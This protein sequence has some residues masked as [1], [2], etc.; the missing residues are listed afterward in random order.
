MKIDRLPAPPHSVRVPWLCR[1]LA[2]PLVVWVLAGSAGL[3]AQETIV[4]YQVPAETAQ[5]QTGLE[6]V[7]VGEDFDVANDIIVT[8][9]GIFDS[10]SDGISEGAILTARLWDRAQSPP[11]QLA[12]I[13][14]D[15][16]SPGELV[17]GFRLKPLPEPIRL[18]AGFQGTIAGDGWTSTDS[19]NNSHGNTANVLWT[20]HDGG[21]SILFVGT[22]RYGVGVGEYPG[23]ADGGPAARFAAATFEFQT[24]PSIV[25]G[26]PIVSIRGGDQ[27]IVLTWAAVTQPAAAAKYVVKRADTAAGPFVQ[28][29]EITETTYTDSGLANGAARS[30]IVE[31][32]SAGGKAGPASD[33]KTAAAYLLATDRRIAYFTPASTPGNQSLLN[34]LGM[35]FDVQ[36]PI[37]VTR[38]GVFDANSDGFSNPIDARIFDR[39]SQAVIA[40]VSFSPEDPGVL[41]EGMRFKPLDPPLR[42]E[43]GFKGLIEA[44]GFLAPDPILNSNGNAANA[45]WTLHD[46]NASLVFVQMNLVG[47]I[48][49]E[50]PLTVD[51]GPVARY[52]A[53]TFEYQ[54]LP[55]TVVGTPQASVLRPFED[56]VATLYWPAVTAPL[57][58]AKYVIRR[59]ASES[60]PFTDLG[61]TTDTI[62]R[63]TT[64]QNGSTYYYIVRAV[65]T[66]GEFAESPV[67]TASPN[68]RRAGIAYLVP[69]G[70]AGNQPLGGS[71][72][73]MDFDVAKPIKVTKLGL[74]DDGGDGITMVLT[75]VL[76]DRAT[77]KII[78]QREFSPESQG[79]LVDGSRFLPLDPPIVLDT[80]FQGSIVM[81]FSTGDSERLYNTFGTPN[82]DVA[83]LRTFDGGSISFVGRS[84]YGSSGAFPA[85]TDGGPV[86]RY[87]GATFEF[88]PTAIDRPTFI[89]YAVPA[90]EAGNQN[91]TGAALGM[92]FDVKNEIILTRLGAFDDSSDGIKQTITVKIWNRSVPEAPAV[93]TSLLFTPDS[94]GTLI[95]GSRFKTLLQPVRL[96]T[97]FKG[98]ITTDGYGDTERVKNSH[99]NVANVT[100]TLNDGSGSLV[101][102]GT[103]RYGGA[104]G[105]PATPDGGLAAR[106]AAGTFEFQTTPPSLPGDP[107]VTVQLPSEENAVTLN[108]AAVTAPL[109]AAK[110]EIHRGAAVD[111]PFTALGETTALT[112][113]D[114]TA[115]NGQRYYYVV[116]AVGA[117]GET[118]DYSAPVL[119]TPTAKLPGI[120]YQVPAGLAGN[121]ALGGAAVG[122]DFDVVTPIRVT[123]LGLFD[124]GSDGITMALTAV[125]Y[126]RAGPIVMA[127]REFT[128]ENQGTLVG[129]SRFL[130]LDSPVVLEAGFQ[131]SIVMSFSDG[132]SERLFN[133][134]GNPNPATADLRLYDGG[135]ILFV[136]SSRYGGAGA[137][138]AT[139]DGG[140]VNRYAAATFEFEPSTSEPPISI[141]YAVAAN[142]LKLNWNGGGALQ[143]TDRI[144][145]T[146][147]PVN[148]AA[149]GVEIPLDGGAAAFFRVA[150]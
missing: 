91:V 22:S 97:G 54:V 55:P 49:G 13:D 21:G 3:S 81:W 104:G 68:P 121:Q 133:T 115:Q 65:A 20:L 30:Y 131:G 10:N 101:F 34:P 145:G 149:S 137:Y 76:Y 23:T 139:A 37:V 106:Y 44:D 112:Y 135:S 1:L 39:D 105:Y 33:I 16:S 11:V 72:V 63:D 77:R 86:N 122:M 29:A 111:G 25:P 102:V 70:L 126:D 150:K 40:G 129:G 12:S 59:G 88:E 7:A 148:G 31:A 14:F 134:F 125:L 140:P 94:P 79:E 85:T 19:I 36:N 118:G 45:I 107:I 47:S 38:L 50:Y 46:G 17:G 113:R 124:D 93:V 61:E 144:G 92:D 84:R 66:G 132:A 56:G 108:W 73:G 83:D 96:P 42:L 28:V 109:P 60:G 100:W 26:K 130:A 87:A 9:L 52:A 15:A 114:A 110:Y 146:W 62:Y 99:G 64:V 57:P 53:G 8:K 143:T 43:A 119:G 117:G 67:L 120:A 35:G 127:S 80:G 95:G 116:R 18:V 90:G 32:V 27:Q 98:T 138:P 5:N 141:T 4:A 89:A 2:V 75:A 103:S 142:K 147:T 41:I 6:T 48:P 69:A 123:K 51:G 24:T 78:A 71:S 136:G 58:A 74:F 128:P 82:P